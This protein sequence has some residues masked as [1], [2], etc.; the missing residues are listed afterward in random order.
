MKEIR[1][2]LATR[3]RGKVREI[4][5]AL[6]ELPLQLLTSEDF[7]EWPVPE[8]KG[9][10]FEENAL[11]KAESLAR[12]SGMPSLADDS[13]LEVE[14]LGGAPGV[15]SAHY[16][17]RHGDDAANIARL[18]EE[19][20]GITGEGRRARFVCVLALAGPRGEK[21]LVREA[22]EGRIAEEPRGEGGFGYD[23]V[24]VPRGS[25]LTMAELD[26]EEKN[27][28]SHRGR[29]LRRLRELLEKGEPDWLF[30]SPE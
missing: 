11:E 13:G 29:A 7:P 2:A 14:A 17:G 9:S 10:T 18:L 21:L 8:E 20:E 12:F 1:L 23:P 28:L 30:S 3:N 6:R 26:L 16:A 15:S 24:F 27:S 25:S 4:R 19:M 5:E 22:C